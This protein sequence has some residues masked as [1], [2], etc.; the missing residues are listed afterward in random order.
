VDRW[1]KFD[2]LSDRPIL[3]EWGKFSRDP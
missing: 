1:A 3:V 2:N